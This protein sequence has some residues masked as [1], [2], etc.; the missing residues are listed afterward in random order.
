MTKGKTLFDLRWPSTADFTAIANKWQ[1]DAADILLAFIWDAYDQL[2][3]DVLDQVDDSK[4]EEDLER[5]ITQLLEAGIH[6]VMTGDEPF[7]VQHGPYE[8]GTRDEAPAQPPLYDIAFVLNA[9]PRIMW[10]CEA[11]VLH[12]D[13]SVAKYVNDINNEFLTC[14]YAPF[15][16][17]GAMLGYLF[18]GSP[19]KVF[20]NIE[21]KVPCKLFIP[22]H[23][24]DR[25]QRYSDHKRSVPT[26]KT[27]PVTFRCH[28]LILQIM[29]NNIEE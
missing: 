29:Q 21:K 20:T 4:N 8:Y 3:C 16:S 27:Y 22:S 17:E 13:G 12:T 15:S 25:T 26:G 11:K 18:S 19:D 14:R 1:Q 24:P 28:H 9:N 7:Y 6:R 10:P 2:K 5:C 23:N